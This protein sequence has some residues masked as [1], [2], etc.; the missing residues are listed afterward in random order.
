MLIVHCIIWQISKSDWTQSR[1]FPIE[2]WS[3]AQYLIFIT[4][5]S[6]NQINKDM[7]PQEK[8]IVT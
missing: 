3:F 2:H 8:N 4:E 7:V 5:T 1:S 6:E